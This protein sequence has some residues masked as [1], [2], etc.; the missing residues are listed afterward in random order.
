MDALAENYLNGSF[1]GSIEFLPHIS[2]QLAMWHGDG[3]AKT[4][5][6][7]GQPTNTTRM[8]VQAIGAMF[9]AFGYSIFHVYVLPFRGFFG[10]IT[11]FGQNFQIK[12]FELLRFGL[13]NAFV[14]GGQMNNLT[15]CLISTVPAVKIPKINF[16]R[17]LLV[18]FSFYIFFDFKFD[19]FNKPGHFDLWVGQLKRFLHSGSTR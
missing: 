14:N 19:G 15:A 5:L 16:F 7:I 12:R 4:P 6:E 13:I 10:A 17:K 2:Q 3:H 8:A 11:R 1:T 9:R 18:P